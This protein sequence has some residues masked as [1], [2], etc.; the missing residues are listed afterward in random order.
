VY[1][2]GGTYGVYGYVNNASGFG[3]DAY[4]GNSSGTGLIASGNAVAGSYLTDGSGAAFTGSNGIY[5]KGA[6]AAD[7][8]GV[9]AIGNNSSTIYTLTAGS[10]GAFTAYECGVYGVSTAG[11]SEGGYF[12]SDDGYDYAYVSYYN[13][14]SYKINGTGTVATIVNDTN[15]GIVNMFCPEAP[16]V[17]LQDYGIGKLKNGKAYIEIDP[18]FANNIVVDEEHPLKVFIQ[19]EGDCNGVYVANKSIKGFEVRELQNGTSDV[20]FSWSI[21]ANRKDE[22]KTNRKGETKTSHYSDLRFPPAPGPMETIEREETR[23]AE[24]KQPSGKE[25]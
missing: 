14:T 19:L 25:K 20:S 4:N 17:L 12:A 9:V 1:A 22:T 8:T 15:G 16:E 11:Y 18:I 2:S 23:A 7:G 10:G 5:A 6:T 24:A 3:V 13:G 21:I